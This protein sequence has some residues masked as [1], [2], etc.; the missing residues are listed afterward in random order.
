MAAPK[1]GRVALMRVLATH[2]TELVMLAVPGFN[3]LNSVLRIVQAGIQNGDFEVLGF[4]EYAKSSDGIVNNMDIDPM[5]DGIA[6]VVDFS[7]YA[8]FTAAR[9]LQIR[10]E[11]PNDHFALAVLVDEKNAD[12]L[13]KMVARRTSAQIRRY[14]SRDS[15]RSA[16]HYIDKRVQANAIPALA[17]VLADGAV[18]A[19]PDSYAVVAL[20]QIAHAA[21]A[22][23][24]AETASPDPL[25]VI[26]EL[27]QQQ[28]ALQEELAAK[29]KALLRLD[30]QAQASDA[31]GIDAS[32]SNIYS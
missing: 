9:I 15:G 5:L 25:A 6:N 21:P 12:Q 26:N 29:D 23:R 28:A 10:D 32:S 17:P 18:E 24:Q 27:K 30:Q 8:G 2:H 22:H 4:Q 3:E 20:D 16:A 1:R 11:L 13:V 31:H 19:T 7:E 14:D